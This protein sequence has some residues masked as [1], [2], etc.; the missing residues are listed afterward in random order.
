MSLP[1]DDRLA[2]WVLFLVECMPVIHAGPDNRLHADNR[3]TVT[4]ADEGRKHS[5]VTFSVT[6]TVDPMMIADGFH[7]SK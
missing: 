6:F 4:Q 5:Y 7:C 1:N 3:H 2:A